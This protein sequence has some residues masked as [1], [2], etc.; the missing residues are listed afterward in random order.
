MFLPSSFKPNSF[1]P[2]SWRMSGL[3][4]TTDGRSGY[5][6]LFFTQM[7]EEALKKDAER[8]TEETKDVETEQDAVRKVEAAPARAKKRKKVTT[9]TSKAPVVPFVPL[10]R[11]PQ[12]PTLYETLY[13]LPLYD[14][15]AIKIQ[16]QTL[17]EKVIQLDNERV[18]RRKK[19]RDEEVFLLLA[20]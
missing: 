13:R 1:L 12:E 10:R 4:P 19:R 3:V 18:K 5:W 14:L 11:P 8:A 6:R 7:Q 20:A 16:T 15:S 2:E 9:K 17:V